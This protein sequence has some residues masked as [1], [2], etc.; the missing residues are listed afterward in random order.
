MPLFTP[1]GVPYYTGSDSP[2][3]AVI[4]L[5][6]A[7]ALD[8]MVISAFATAAARTAAYAG[9]TI[10]A[11]K[12]TFRQ[13]ANV[14]EWWNGVIWHPMPGGVMGTATTA[15]QT[16]STG[17]NGTTEALSAGLSLTI[18]GIV[19]GLRYRI[20]WGGWYRA[21]VAATN[22]VASV[23]ASQSAITTGSPVVAGCNKWI[24]QINFGPEDA[25]EGIWTPGASGTWNLQL[26]IK[27]S[28]G[29]GASAISGG[30]Q[31]A[32]LSVYAS[33]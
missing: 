16:T 13:D 5:A 25:N 17:A 7:N 3:L 19:A 18:V 31:N 23:H 28:S 24:A 10:P 32:F 21:T 30:A 4:T 11:N 33:A 20:A 29:T 1:G 27:S 22:A 14:F 12:L 6:Q 9:T 8:P 26:G 2:N 15:T